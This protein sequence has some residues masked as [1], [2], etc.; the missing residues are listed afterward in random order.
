MLGLFELSFSP[1][2]GYFPCNA[3]T[4]GLSIDG[5]AQGYYVPIRSWQ[6]K[7]SVVSGSILTNHLMPERRV[8]NIRNSL[9]SIPGL[10]STSGVS[11]S[12][13]WRAGPRTR[14]SP[15]CLQQPEK[16]PFSIKHFP[17]QQLTRLDLVF[18]AQSVGIMLAWPQSAQVRNHQCFTSTRDLI[19]DA[20]LMKQRRKMPSTRQDQNAEHH[21]HESF[22]LPLH[23]NL[24]PPSGLVILKLNSTIGL[25]T[26]ALNCWASL[27]LQLQMSGKSNSGKSSVQWSHN[28]TATVRPGLSTVAWWSNLIQPQVS[29]L[30]PVAWL[31]A[32]KLG[33]ASFHQIDGRS[34]S[35]ET[36]DPQTTKSRS[37]LSCLKGWIQITLERQK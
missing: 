18:F 35:S 1:I 6:I 14:P 16:N 3:L 24:C 15:N 28:P 11:C 26:R 13:R 5:T 21:C 37:F 36:K 20:L 30:E 32:F 33:K 34:M 31:L 25:S 10:G 17:K 12:G 23:C 29:P 2:T 4:P 19:K 8:Q 27:L 7:P 9:G 22:A